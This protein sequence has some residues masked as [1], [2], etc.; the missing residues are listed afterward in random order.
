MENE[1]NNT[2]QSG[3][4][5]PEGVYACQKCGE[6]ALIVPEMAKKLPKCPVCGGTIWYKV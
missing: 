1:V 3:E 6:G 4:T 5:P 2:Y